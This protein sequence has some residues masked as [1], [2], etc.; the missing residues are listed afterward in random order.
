VHTA[1]ASLRQELSALWNGKHAVSLDVE[2][3]NVLNLLTPRWGLMRVPN[4]VALQHVRH[5]VTVT[6]SQPVFR[7]DP[8]QAANSADNVES[9]YQIQL[10][11]RY[12]F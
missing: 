4:T 5:N 3:F 11:L 10:A 9:A 2:I 8:N 1:N 12:R 7:F 6:P